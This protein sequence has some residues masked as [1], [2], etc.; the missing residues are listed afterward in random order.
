M[1]LEM[2]KQWVLDYE[3]YNSSEELSLQDQEL[4]NVARGATKNAYAPYSQFLVAAAA[5]LEDGTIHTGTNQ[6]NASYPVGMC[7]EQTLILGL[8]TKYNQ[9]KINSI[10]VSYSNLNGSSNHPV[11]PCG[12]CRQFLNEFESRLQA[13]IRIIMS[14]LSGKVWIVNSIADLIPLAFSSDALI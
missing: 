13:P 5:R 2:K 9:F 11:S 10:A 1:E 12:K 7:A 14:G 3:E 8:T 6:E 4:L